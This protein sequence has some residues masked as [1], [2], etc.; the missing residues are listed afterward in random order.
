MEKAKE[1]KS[2]EKKEEKKKNQE[3]EKEKDKPRKGPATTEAKKS[4]AA[5]IKNEKARQRAV[6]PAAHFKRRRMVRP[7]E[8]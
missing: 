2:E 4:N 7:G 8:V 3:K 6:A 5:S 1:K